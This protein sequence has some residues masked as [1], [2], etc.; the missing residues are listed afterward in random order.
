MSLK[1]CCILFFDSLL[2]DKRQR[3]RPP[4]STS[5]ACKYFSYFKALHRCS[6]IHPHELG[7]HLMVVHKLANDAGTELDIKLDLEKFRARTHLRRLQF[8]NRK[9]F[10]SNAGRFFRNHVVELT[11]LDVNASL[12]GLHFIFGV[13]KSRRQLCKFVLHLP[14]FSVLALRHCKVEIKLKLKVELKARL[15][16]LCKSIIN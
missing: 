7:R 13:N 4:F 3:G 14:N 6:S 12:Q 15:Y 11:L 8:Q 16:N 2:D 9:D 5:N 10:N 1:K